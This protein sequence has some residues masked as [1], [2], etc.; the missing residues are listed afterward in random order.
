MG[1]RAL[2]APILQTATDDAPPDAT[3]ERILAAA[4]EQ[5]EEL[6]IRRTTMED[7]ARR[8]RVSRVT[9]YRRFPGKDRLVEAVILGEAQRFFAELETAVAGLE[10]IE[11]RIVEAFVHTLSA[12]REQRLLNRL[13]RTEP[14]MLLPHL[15]TDGGRVVAAGTAFLAAQMR[16]A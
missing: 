9:I 15:T 6:G 1:E 16:L 5:F 11:E 2:L 12:A 4:L 10:S 8:A 13:L 7:V 14:E 3:T